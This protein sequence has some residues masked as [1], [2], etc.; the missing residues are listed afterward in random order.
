MC[1]GLL[2]DCILVRWYADFAIQS[3]KKNNE[4]RMSWCK[5]IFAQIKTLTGLIKLKMNV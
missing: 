1:L 5:V 4:H 2:S 3:N